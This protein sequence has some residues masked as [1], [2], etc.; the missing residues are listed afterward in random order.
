MANGNWVSVSDT[1]TVRSSDQ[2]RMHVVFDCPLFAGMSAAD[3]A[4]A[5]QAQGAVAAVLSI[6]VDTVAAIADL[7]SFSSNPQHFI[8]AVNPTD[9][10]Q[11]ADVRSAILT[12]LN[13]VNGAKIVPC[14]DFQAGQFEM[15]QASSVFT[16]S[17]QTAVSLTAIAV[18]AVVAILLLKE[19]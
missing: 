7:F 4:T 17:T 16:P 3:I 13:V 14:G 5:V 10:V 6:S 8:I 9:G 1:Q 15:F 18:L 11:V 2:L 12:A 19:L